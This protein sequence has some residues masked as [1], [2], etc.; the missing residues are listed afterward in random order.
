MQGSDVAILLI[1]IACIGFFYAMFT[2]W[3]PESRLA[4]ARELAKLCEWCKERGFE[5]CDEYELVDV[6]YR[7]CINES[8][9]TISKKRVYVVDGKYKFIE[10]V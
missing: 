1:I 6:N 2:I 9:D 10:I 3:L 7:F 8:D 4:E 5:T